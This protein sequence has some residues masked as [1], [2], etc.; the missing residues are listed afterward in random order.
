MGVLFYGSNEPIEIPDRLLAHVKVVVTAKLRRDEKFTL[1]WAYPLGS[2]GG[3]STIWLNSAI[4]LQFVFDSEEPEILDPALLREL[5]DAAN[6]ARG[7][8]IQLDPVM[9]PVPVG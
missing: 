8:T 3:R 4:P 5:A 6:S 1:S 9:A 7:L 2:G